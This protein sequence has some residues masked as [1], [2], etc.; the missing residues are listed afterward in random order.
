MDVVGISFALY[1]LL[2]VGLG[3]YS[4]RFGKADEEDYFLA[5]RRLGPWMASLSASASGSSGWVTMGLVGFAFTN[6]VR[7]YWLLP[8]VAF[9]IL[10]NWFVLAGP[11]GRRARE[12]GAVTI[13][14]VFSLHFGE[15]APLLRIL[16]VI[17]I[18]SA[19]FLYVA[20]Q[21]AAAG[22]AFELGFG[23]VDYRL[24]VVI[25]MVVVLAY[26]VVGGF[27]AACWTDFA[28]SLLMLAA[29]VGL[30]VALLITRGGYGFVLDGLESADPDLVRF[31]PDIGGLALIGFVLGSGALGVNFG[32]PGQPHVLV[33]YMALENSKDVYQGGAIAVTWAM[34]IYWGA[35]TIGLLSRAMA[36]AGD[37]WATTLLPGGGTD[38]ELALI[39]SAQNLMPGVIAGMALAAILAAIASTADSQLVV[40]ASSVASDIVGKVT[41]APAARIRWLIDRGVVL[42]LGVGAALLVIDQD[43]K[44]YNYVLTYGWAMLG[45]AFGPQLALLLLWKRATYAG[46]L[47]GMATG[48]VVTIVWPEVYSGS[49]EMYNL[50]VA[51]IA[52]LVVNVGVSLIATQSDQ[53]P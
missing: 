51:F 30:P 12:L 31:V 11:L 17:V 34:L 24:G 52:A 14:D 6:G 32:Y 35:V 2:I 3:I 46:C 28:Q 23:G 37:E 18:L 20:A 36:S 50:T 25:G 22:K 1:T 43:V 5:G 42:A 21:M 15:R 19:M 26:T 48:F 40:A 27:R 29:L 16:S 4:T 47:A 41:K 13:P 10:F 45:A 7:A 49:V 39:V 9:G 53:E 8:G 33:R 44:V 38:S